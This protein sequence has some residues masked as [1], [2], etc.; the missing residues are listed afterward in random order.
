MTK[1]QHETAMKIINE[2]AKSTD[3]QLEIITDMIKKQSK[4][5]DEMNEQIDSLHKRL[6]KL[7]IEVKIWKTN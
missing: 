5:F 6:L 7:E 4:V 1:E 3:R 2:H